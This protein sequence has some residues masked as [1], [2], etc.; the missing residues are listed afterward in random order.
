M[1]AWSLNRE[2][3]KTAGFWPVWPEDEE[4]SE[5]KA[6]AA[7]GKPAAQ[8]AMPLDDPDAQA[9]AVATA[10]GELD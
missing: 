10:R 4:D 5:V 6:A 3:M 9:A 1:T 7:N 8:A 2:W